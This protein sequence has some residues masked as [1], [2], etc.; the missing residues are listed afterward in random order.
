MDICCDEKPMIERNFSSLFPISRGE[1]QCA[2]KH[3]WGAG[4]RTHYII[5]YVLS[6]KGTFYCGTKKY[7]LKKGQ[8]FVIFPYTIVKYQADGAQPWHYTW[9]TFSGDESKEIFSKLGVS[10]QNPIIDGV[11]VDEAKT[12]IRQMPSDTSSDFSTLHFTA[13]LYELISLFFKSNEGGKANSYLNSAIQYIKA[14]FSEEITVENISSFVGISRK[15][16]FALFKSALGLSPKEYIVNYRIE[17]A[18]HLL[19]SNDFSIGEV[20]WSV[21]YHDQLAFSK[22]FKEKTGVS[23]TKYRKN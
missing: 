10:P 15:Y 3:F 2:P 19:L 5:H 8:A 14:H 18:K 13:L 22:I 12:L 11:D 4:V 23:P 1:E 17:K 7:S 20:A 6:G 9:V 21:G 16:L